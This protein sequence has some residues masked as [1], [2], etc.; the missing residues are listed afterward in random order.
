MIETL[1]TES[2]PAH[3]R[4]VVESGPLIQGLAH[5]IRNPLAAL[6]SIVQV[7][8]TSNDLP[9]P[10]A[11]S[12]TQIPGLLLRI[13]AALAGCIALTRAAPSSRRRRSLGE[14]IGSF[15]SGSSFTGLRVDVTVAEETETLVSVDIIQRIVSA[16]AENARQANATELALDAEVV[17]D[18]LGARV[19]VLHVSDNGDGMDAATREAAFDPFFSTRPPQIGLGLTIARKLAR[20]VGGDLFF[21]PAAVGC[22]LVLRMPAT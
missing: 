7:L 17:D 18:D 22:D 14:L 10:A 15:A 4:T 13:D 3:V 8:A 1:R 16:L 12:L 6:H 5:H 20:D 19:L 11:A 21:V 2:A 9:P